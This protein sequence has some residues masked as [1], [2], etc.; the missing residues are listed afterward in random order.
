MSC[1]NIIATSLGKLQSIYGLIPH[2]K[3]KGV[4]AKKVMQRLL[5]KRVEDESVV[6]DKDANRPNGI[7]SDQ[8][9]EIDT[10]IM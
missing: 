9:S 5:H 1:L 3:S 6:Q 7:S 8:R 4:G 2:I 10:M